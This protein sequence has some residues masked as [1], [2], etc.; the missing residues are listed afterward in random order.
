M[1]N[2]EY[3]NQKHSMTE[4]ICIRSLGHTGDCWGRWDRKYLSPKTLIRAEF[5]SPRS[6][7][8]GMHIRYAENVIKETVNGKS[9]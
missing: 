8:P 1:W 4:A 7:S 5:E 6:T 2:K 3:C 9:V